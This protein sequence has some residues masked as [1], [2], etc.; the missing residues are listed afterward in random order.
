MGVHRGQR[1]LARP[2]FN[3]RYGFLPVECADARKIPRKLQKH[4]ET[5]GQNSFPSKT[6]GILYLVSNGQLISRR[7]ALNQVTQ[8][9]P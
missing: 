5:L 7:F 9:H 6:T 8:K 3:E 4:A 1:T 2:D